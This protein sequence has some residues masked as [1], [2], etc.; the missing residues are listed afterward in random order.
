MSQDPSNAN[1][2]RAHI[3]NMAAID[4][5]RDI[6]VDTECYQVGTGSDTMT[7]TRWSVSIHSL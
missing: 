6:G 1:T 3:T 7:H 2:P 4:C 5:L